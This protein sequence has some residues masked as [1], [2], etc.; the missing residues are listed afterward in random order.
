M[1]SLLVAAAARRCWLLARSIVVGRCRGALPQSV[2]A[3]RRREDNLFFG[4]P[5]GYRTHFCHEG[6]RAAAHGQFFPSA[7]DTD[8]HGDALADEQDALNRRCRRF[9]TGALV[10]FA[11]GGM[12]LHRVDEDFARQVE[13]G[14]IAFD[15]V[16]IEGS[17]RL[18]C[19]KAQKRRERDV[20]R[21]AR[22]ARQARQ[23]PFE[24]GDL[25]ISSPVGL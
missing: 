15:V 22:D 16:S 4:S 5:E 24:K 18:G 8:F 23:A 3:D 1:S 19:A 21:D 25:S 9:K 12:M 7:F 14:R 13:L 6:C 20:R 11:R 2:A 17:D 10:A